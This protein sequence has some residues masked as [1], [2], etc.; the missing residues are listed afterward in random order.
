MNFSQTYRRINDPIVPSPALAARTVA[1][2]R[3]RRF[4]LR[5]LAAIAAA[6]AVV[7]ATPALAAQTGPGYELLYAIFPA[8]AQFFQPVQQSCTSSGVTM[9]VAAVRIEGDTAEAY[10][11]LSGE[12]VDGGCD[13]FDSYNFHLPF[14][15]IGTCV[16][17]GYDEETHTAAF[18]CT[19]RTMDGSPIP[20]GGKM[21]FSVDCFLTGKTERRDVEIP[22]DLA[23]YTGEAGAM[24]PDAAGFAFTGG[25]VSDDRSRALLDDTR[26]LVPGEPLAAPVEGLDVTAAGYVDGLFHIQLCRGDASQL[27]NNGWLWLADGDGNP[28]EPLYAAYFTSAPDTPDRQD[29]LDFV[30]DIPRETLAGCTL[31]GNFST[32]CARIDGGWQVTFPLLDTLSQAEPAETSGGSGSFD[33]QDALLAFVSQLEAETGRTI[34]HEDGFHCRSLLATDTLRASEFTCPDGGGLRVWLQNV[35]GGE[36]AGLWQAYAYA[37]TK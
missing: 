26:V 13:L 36:A 16:P 22:L 27:D 10:I 35:P 29:Y 30:F 21:T 4:P 11:T 33:P 37:W 7:L 12:A 31:L 20:T 28:V 32:S 24:A 19:T 34:R 3:R 8:A 9:E 6:A 25:G 1:Q 17:A 5:R 18:L 15:R 23:D 14:G 2:T